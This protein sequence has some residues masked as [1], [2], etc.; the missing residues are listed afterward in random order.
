VACL[1]VKTSLSVQTYDRNDSVVNHDLRR[2]FLT[3][4]GDD[5]VDTDSSVAFCEHQRR[6]RLGHD[7]RG[8]RV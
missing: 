5:M 3:G 8:A 4:D 6:G 1:T 2:S 7:R